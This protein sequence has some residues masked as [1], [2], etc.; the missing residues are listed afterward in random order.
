MLEKRR[1]PRKTYHQFVDFSTGHQSKLNAMSDISASG[2]LIRT[3]R[4]PPPI[5]SEITLNFELMDQ[6]IYVAAAVVRHD[7]R[8]FGAEFIPENAEEESFIKALVEMLPKRS[9]MNTSD[10]E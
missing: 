2:I 9:A 3:R 10:E 7:I 6:A 5:G 4:M 8:G 1:H